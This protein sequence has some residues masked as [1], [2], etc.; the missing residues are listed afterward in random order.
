L[1]YAL[2]ALLAAAVAHAD[3]GLSLQTNPADPRSG[4]TVSLLS[5]AGYTDGK[6]DGEIPLVLDY[7]TPTA[8]I[9]VRQE[10][11]QAGWNY[12]SGWYAQDYRPELTGHGS[13]VFGRLYVWAN[14]SY[15]P[16]NIQL[17]YYWFI[18][19]D[20]PSAWDF[21]LMMLYAPVASYTGRTLWQIPASSTK[22][23]WIALV[24]VPTYRTTDGLTGYQFEFRAHLVPEPAA[25]TWLGALAA[26]VLG[27]WAVRT[28]RRS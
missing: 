5:Q 7:S 17:A 12:E 3:W 13:I 6:D 24:D 23:E 16:D 1:L 18:G 21:T 14:P 10:T 9:R 19:Q 28:G 11:G 15:A 27:R 2:V 8:R 25:F 4:S 26:S 20:N 22:T